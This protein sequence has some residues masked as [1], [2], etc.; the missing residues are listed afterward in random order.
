M[1]KGNN[2]TKFVIFNNCIFN[3]IRV[4]IPKT[5][6]YRISQKLYSS[7]IGVVR[8]KA[9]ARSYVYGRKKLTNILSQ[10]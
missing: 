4:V 7:H 5:L 10:L 9:L 2:P 8:M 6:R 1:K 3:G